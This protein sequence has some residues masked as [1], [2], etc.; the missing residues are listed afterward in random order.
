MRGYKATESRTP[1][2]RVRTWNQGI[3][4]DVAG[5]TSL[6][7]TLAQPLPFAFWFLGGAELVTA[8]RGDVTR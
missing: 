4:K 8:E 2:V 3:A 6:S 7:L 1:E 5:R